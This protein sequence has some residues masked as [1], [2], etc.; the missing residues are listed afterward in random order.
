[1]ETS[2][3]NVGHPLDKLGAVWA[4]TLII[5]GD[6][7]WGTNSG[8]GRPP[9]PNSTDKILVVKYSDAIDFLKTSVEMERDEIT[10]VSIRRMK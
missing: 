8:F 10:S 9:F 3:Q 5:K 1:M 7:Y 4:I 6:T 2:R